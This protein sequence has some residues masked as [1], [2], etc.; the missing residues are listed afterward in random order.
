MA[1]K[2]REALEK[3]TS[4]E[5][6]ICSSGVKIWVTPLPADLLRR[7]QA[8]LEKD[9]PY[10]PVPKKTVEVLGGTEE[11]DDIN[12]PEY[13]TEKK[14][15]DVI[16]LGEQGEA[17][18]DYCAEVDGGIGEYEAKISRIE[19][20]TGE[21]YPTD[22]DDRRIQFLSEYVIRS[23]S[24][25]GFVFASAIEQ[26]Q[27]TDPEVVTR[28]DSFRDNMARAGTNGHTPSGAD[29]VERLAVQPA[30]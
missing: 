21:D 10:P 19:K 5:S 1:S 22:L 29:E 8:K 18:L 7:L 11:V 17:I 16:R 3:V 9:H 14:A 13:L 2:A 25:W 20:R 6:R 28:M 15:I 27:V 4:G 12:N 24:D 23:P 30:I 26:T